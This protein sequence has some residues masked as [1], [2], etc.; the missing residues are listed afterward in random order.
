ME[1]RYVGGNNGTGNSTSHGVY[2]RNAHGQDILL[3]P[4]GITWR[5]IGGSI[6]LYFFAG[7]SQAEVT[8]SYQ[9]DAIGLPAMQQYSTLGYH[10]ARWGYENWTVLQEV[11]DNFAR[12]E[13][14]LEYIWCVPF[15]TGSESIA[16]NAVD[17]ERHR[18]LL[19]V[20]RLYR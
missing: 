9:R 1:T 6:D 16:D 3:R 18:P 13:I 15:Q 8:R 7:P 11:V 2:L 20:Q 12:F 5:P 14:P 4:E 17:Q 10:Q 19:L